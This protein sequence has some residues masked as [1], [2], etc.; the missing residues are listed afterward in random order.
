[1]EKIEKSKVD[2]EYL[3]LTIKRHECIWNRNSAEYHMKG[4]KEEAWN[5][6]CEELIPGWQ[7]SSELVKHSKQYELKRRW[8]NIR[9][10]YK[11][12]LALQLSGAIGQTKRKRY[13]FSAN[14]D[15]LRPL[16]DQ[17]LIEKQEQEEPEEEVY[18]EEHLYISDEETPLKRKDA[19]QSETVED[20]KHYSISKSVDLLEDD[21]DWLFLRSLLADMKDMN[22]AQKLE[23]K[24]GILKL[25]KN[26]LC[27]KDG[28]GVDSKVNIDFV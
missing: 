10:Y 26:I 25:Y 21:S 6:I 22:R 5:Q 2:S 3:I 16:M 1:M 19:R 18:L 23:F 4:M 24:M 27:D 9:D 15:F 11:K 8:H 20:S 7:D 14:L 13:V 28:Y 17:S 12:D